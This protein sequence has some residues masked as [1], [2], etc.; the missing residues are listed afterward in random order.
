[1]SFTVE[2][3]A[4][5]KTRQAIVQLAMLNETFVFCTLKFTL[6]TLPSQTKCQP[7]NST[8]YDITMNALDGLIQMYFDHFQA[9]LQLVRHHW[10][11]RILD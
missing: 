5:V 6:S 4:C 9:L 2:V 1:M 7:P 11:H 3:N 8:Y 10:A